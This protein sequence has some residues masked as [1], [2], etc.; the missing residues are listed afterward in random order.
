MLTSCLIGSRIAIRK[1][2]P[3]PNVRRD[4]VR[5]IK[6][7]ATTSDP[8]EVPLIGAPRIPPIVGNT[9]KQRMALS[10]MEKC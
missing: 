9:A 4:P 2:V 3:I 1:R 5:T 8:T 10:G 6:I 7:V